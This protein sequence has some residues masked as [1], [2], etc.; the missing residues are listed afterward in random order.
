MISVRGVVLPDCRSDYVPGITYHR[1][2]KCLEFRLKRYVLWVRTRHSH[3][4]F[5]TG[6]YHYFRHDWRFRCVRRYLGFRN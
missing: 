4:E 1:S 6:L 5:N 2:G 3:F